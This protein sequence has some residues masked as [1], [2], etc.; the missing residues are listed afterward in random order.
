MGRIF[1]FDRE[2]DT[3]RQ[4]PDINGTIKPLDKSNLKNAEIESGELV[5]NPDMGVVS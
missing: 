4:D 5:L 3:Q 2:I 1:L